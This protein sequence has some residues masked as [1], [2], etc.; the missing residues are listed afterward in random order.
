MGRL[1]F[2]NVLFM[3]NFTFDMGDPNFRTGS[4]IKYLE[5]LA[6]SL[7]KSNDLDIKYLVSNHTFESIKRTSKS[8][9]IN[10]ENSFIINYEKNMDIFGNGDWFIRK[11]Y[12]DSFN[13]EEL[14]Y[15]FGFLKSMFNGWEPDLIVCWEFPTT[16]FRKLFPKALVIDL[17]P[18]LFM[19]PPF[20]RTISIDPIGLYKDSVFRD[21]S[22]SELKAKETELD[23]YYKIR[24]EYEAFFEG[25]SV[26]DLILSK[27]NGA[28]KF[29]KF[30]L[31]P[32]QISQY[33]GFYENC[34]YQSQF[35]FLIDVLRNTPEDTGVIVTQ[36]I[37][38]FVTEKAINDKN[39]DYLR[40]TFPN[41]L[42]SK[43]F[44]AIDNISQ[45]IAP[46]AD[47]TCSISSTIG[48]QAKFFNRKLIS[49]SRSHLGYLADQNNLDSE[50]NRYTN[51]DHIMAVMLS[52]QTLLESRLLEDPEYLTS[53]LVEMKENKDKG[54]T[55]LQLLP[56]KQFIKNVKDNPIHYQAASSTSAAVRQ[57]QKL[58]L[59]GINPENNHLKVLVDKIKHAKMVSF[60]VFDT[61]LCRA[62]FK[63]EDVFLMMQREL[64][65][66]HPPFDL[67]DHFVQS[68]AKLRSGV[69]RQLRRQRDAELALGLE[70]AV[71]EL[72]IE[73]VYSFMLERFNGDANLVDKLINFEQEMEWKVLRARP[74]GQ[75]LFN[76]AIKLGKPVI[77]VS[78]FIHDESFV[79]KAL[80]NAGYTEYTTLYVSSK[81][82]K[83]KHSGDLFRHIAEEDQLDPTTIIHIGD[84]AIGDLT[85]AYESGWN[86]IRISSSRER[87]LEI[88]RE[89]NLS[90]AIIDNSF[91]LR[92][93]LS[94]F[95]E[96]FYHTKAF[97]N[98]KE[99]AKEKARSFVENGIEFG[100]LVLGPMLYSFSEWII[101]EAKKKNCES[102]L[103]FARDCYLPYKIVEKILKARGEKNISINYLATSRRGLMGLNIYTPE[104]YLKVNFSDFNRNKPLED[105]FA[106]RFGLDPDSISESTISRWDVNDLSINVG[107]VSP[108]AIYGIVYDHVRENWNEVY[109]KLTQK[110]NA[111]KNYLSEQGVDV[112]KKTLAIDFGYKGS[113]HRML[114]SLFEK[115]LHAGFFMTYANDF[116]HDPIENGASYFL[117]NLNPVIKSGIVLSHNLILE[118][119]V[120]EPTGSLYEVMQVDGQI[121]IV[122]EELGS[123]EHLAKVNSIHTG[124]LKFAD[125]WLENFKHFPGIATVELNSADYLLTNI[126]RKPTKTEAEILKGMIFDNAFAGHANRYILAPHKGYK[127]SQSIWKEGHKELYTNTEAAKKN[128]PAKNEK[129]QPKK[130]SEQV[131][132]QSKPP[133]QKQ[134]VKENANQKKPV[135]KP[136]V[137]EN[138]DNKSTDKKQRFGT[139]KLQ[140]NKIIVDGQN[141]SKNIDQLR[142]LH[143]E[144]FVEA[145]ALLAKLSPSAEAKK[146][147]AE[148]ISNHSKS[149]V[150]AK[151]LKEY[152]GISKAKLPRKG[153]LRAYKS[154]IFKK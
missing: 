47:H 58:G 63:P 112:S 73:E 109:G 45:F 103:F 144:A 60:D 86:S 61:L 13:S 71:E 154:L 113:T 35:D 31:V 64:A 69:E 120:N 78:D 151:L 17:M 98:D 36:Y 12:N 145:V 25:L 22:L 10:S 65:S 44:E 3:S 131:V 135:Q 95:S 7:A 89:R 134:V 32:L 75:F 67:P 114:R 142:V 125:N 57:L 115:D 77:I 121:K 147:Y 111:Y 62:V 34:H 149:Y 107:K 50:E 141:F 130:P 83:K 124:V 68:F 146:Q 2:N 136:K 21:P 20:P 132:V 92:T 102:I 123:V 91:V 122:K 87:A 82:G 118:T 66:D 70:D 11:S 56:N 143:R 14:G 99:P 101:N 53:L 117:S 6:K 139:V 41:F 1:P 85:K 54:N 23:A 29:K 16:I 33:F 28:E 38:G 79:A 94:L 52:R 72:T 24:N 119:L 84:N 39:I 59:S 48:L 51:N 27:L 43:E 18:G 127:D 42:Y 55:G 90:P 137:N 133:V 5:P 9:S 30:T 100:F 88:V 105:L 153:K 97:E 15:I 152:G 46:W 150:A 129:V 110:R 8:T 40:Q 4:Y 37:S 116:G 26:K 19:R 126:L 80:N 96:E 49:P 93:A 140:N 108:A 76:Q 128:V 138:K 81:Y 148:M 104:D 74:I 106:N